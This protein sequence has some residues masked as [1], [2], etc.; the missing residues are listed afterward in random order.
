VSLRLPGTK[1]IMKEIGGEGLGVR[2]ARVNR[3]FFLG[4]GFFFGGWRKKKPEST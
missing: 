3:F 4:G 1:K 2:T